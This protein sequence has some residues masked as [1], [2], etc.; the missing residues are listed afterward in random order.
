MLWL[1]ELEG[2]VV[3][4]VLPRMMRGRPGVT[5]ERGTK[6]ELDVREREC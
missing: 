6:I 1:K 5:G 3:W 4:V 2:E